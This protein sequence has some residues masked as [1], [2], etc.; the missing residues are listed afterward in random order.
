M[1]LPQSKLS[2][3]CWFDW[4][5]TPYGTAASPASCCDCCLIGTSCTW[6]WRWLAI[7]ALPLPPEMVKGAS[8]DASKTASH[9]HLSWRLYCSTS[10]VHLRP[11]N[12]HLQ[13]VCICWRSSNHACW[14]RLAGGG[15]GADQGHG[16]ARWIPPDL[17]DEAQYHENGVSGLPSQQQGS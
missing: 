12:H 6:S 8:Y 11:A 14:W 13:K 2:S 7:A 3:S 1:V 17:K 10:T 16:N 9:R 15:R 4:P 5:T